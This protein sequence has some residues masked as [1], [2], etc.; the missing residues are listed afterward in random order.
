MEIPQK[1][2]TLP[3]NEFT[4]KIYR[5]QEEITMKKSQEINKKIKS[6]EQAP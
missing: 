5:P 3:E 4:I 2:T 6:E 1:K